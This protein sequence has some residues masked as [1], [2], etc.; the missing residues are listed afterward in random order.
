[1]GEAERGGVW[2]GGVEQ[3][4]PVELIWITPRRRQGEREREKAATP[5]PSALDVAIER[6]SGESLGQARR[7]RGS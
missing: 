6:A 4:R 2:G 3:P 7:K 1:V 5:E